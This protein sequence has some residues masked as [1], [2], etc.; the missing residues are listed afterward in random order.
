MNQPVQEGALS[1]SSLSLT[2]VQFASGD[3]VAYL[4]A[5]VT[6]TPLAILISYVTVIGSRREFGAIFMLL[7]QLCCEGLNFVLK[8]T[9]RQDR[10]TD[11]LGTGYGMPSS[12]AQFMSFWG[13]YLCLY[14]YR[15]I[16]FEHNIWKIVCGLF[17]LIVSFTVSYSRIHLNYHTKAQVV[18]GN[19]V[20]CLFAIGWFILFEINL[21][22]AGLY[23]RLSSLKICQYAYFKDSTHIDNVVKFEYDNCVKARGIKNAKKSQ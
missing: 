16:H 20:G 4:L 12:H 5:Y 8:K 10:P 18:V 17:A 14:I 11:H 3:K 1:L 22:S 6:L 13:V 23:D 19:I 7:G 2:H 21:R 15:K 9:I